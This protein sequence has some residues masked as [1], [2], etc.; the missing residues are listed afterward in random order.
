[1]PRLT[2]TGLVKRD[3]YGNPV[4]KGGK[5]TKR[6]RGKKSKKRR[7]SRRKTTSRK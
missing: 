2:P 5:R 4:Y 6:R 3:K 1:M 7:A